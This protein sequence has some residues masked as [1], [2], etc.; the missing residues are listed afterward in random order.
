[1]C[2]KD[3]WKEATN[4]Q[5]LERMNEDD[6]GRL[7]DWAYI[8]VVIVVTRLFALY[9]AAYVGC[10]LIGSPAAGA[11][12]APRVPFIIHTADIRR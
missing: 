5:W 12:S 1:M 10:D 4:K 7:C 8:A 6:D 3:A 9:C 11:R 2:T